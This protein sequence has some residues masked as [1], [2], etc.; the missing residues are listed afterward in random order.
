M[1]S[2][3]RAYSKAQSI[4]NNF[5]ATPSII[6]VDRVPN[7][8]SQIFIGNQVVYITPAYQKND[9]MTI[10]QIQCVPKPVPKNNSK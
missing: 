3:N 1:E 6:Q 9:Y 4:C 7:S 8:V 10:M 5:A 2:D